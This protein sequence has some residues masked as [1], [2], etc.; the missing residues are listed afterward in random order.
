MISFSNERNI[1]DFVCY[2]F[3]VPKSIQTEIIK[4]NQDLLCPLDFTSSWKSGVNAQEQIFKA[5]GAIVPLPN[6]MANIKLPV[7]M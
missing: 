6:Y 1:R 3:S 2:I 4:K 5:F 7:D